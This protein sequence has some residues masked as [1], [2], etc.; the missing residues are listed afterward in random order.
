MTNS[1]IN[2]DQIDNNTFKQLSLWFNYDLV[3]E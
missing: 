3:D 2:Y 1:M